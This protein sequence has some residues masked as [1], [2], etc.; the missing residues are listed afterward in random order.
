M[1]FL[2]VVL[3]PYR[4]DKDLK[5]VAQQPV[6]VKSPSPT[7]PSAP[8][9]KPVTPAPEQPPTRGEEEEDTSPPPPTVG[10]SPSRPASKPSEPKIPDI[11][12][13]LPTLPGPDLSPKK[14]TEPP[15][16][17]APKNPS[18][19]SNSDP[20]E[21]VPA[22][23]QIPRT[24]LAE[25]KAATVFIKIRVHSI[26]GSGSG[27]VIHVDGDNA[28]IVTNNHVA[29]P[30]VGSRPPQ[31]AECEVIFHSSHPTEFR[32]KAELIAFDEHHDLAVLQVTGVRNTAQFPKPI[33]VNDRPVIAE[34]TPIY[35]F[36]F[37]FGEDLSVTRGANP[38]ITISKGT[39]TSLRG[40]KSGDTAFIQIDADANPGNSGG[41]VV[42]GR[43]RLVGVL[44]G[45]RPGTKLNV[46]IP[47]VEV[48]RMLTGRVDDLAFRVNRAS[49]DT[50]SLD[51]RGHLIDPMSRVASASLRVVRRRDR[52]PSHCRRRWRL[53]RFAWRESDRGRDFRED[54]LRD[55]GG[56]DSP[57]GSW[58]GRDSLPT[59]LHRS[60]WH[61]T[62]FRTDNA[63]GPH[64]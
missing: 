64:E 33:N 48:T 21:P 60:G 51:I 5:A 2:I 47:Y 45:G 34:T 10:E 40:D 20:L 61:H 26:S 6:H 9:R 44:K 63:Y 53:A 1:I 7:K 62:L 35:I 32:R 30:K 22:D 36:G 43:G 16:P 23:G 24:L 42:D 38:A 54:C 55:R 58:P 37:P 31:A 39:I 46:A 27:F 18:R 41:P 50:V 4:D 49:R 11:G 19:G 12:S 13:L 3:R 29:R 56:P 8:K 17:K 25:L 57:G 28:L 14:P 59:C 15:P 52:I